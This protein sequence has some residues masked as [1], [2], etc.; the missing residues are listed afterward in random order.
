ML[1]DSA[2]NLQLTQVRVTQT[3]TRQQKV[4]GK[5]IQ[6]PP[7]KGPLLV[8]LDIRR[9]VTHISSKEGPELR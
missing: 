7:G 2:L 8:E 3:P 6:G 5:L 9:S 4:F 1:E